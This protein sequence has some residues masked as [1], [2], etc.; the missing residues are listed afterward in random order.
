MPGLWGGRSGISAAFQRC[1][2][3]L[4]DTLRHPCG[5]IRY[6][7]SNTQIKCSLNK[8]EIY[9]KKIRIVYNHTITQ[10]YINGCNKLKVLFP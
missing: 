3:A 2:K 4:S 8:R 5:L 10:T 9:Y 7:V 6:L 1:R